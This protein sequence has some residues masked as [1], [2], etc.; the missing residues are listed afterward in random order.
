M[1]WNTRSAPVRSTR[2]A[3]PEYFASNA[4][5]TRSAAGRSSE[6][7]QTTLPSF[8]AASI[9]A[10]VTALAGGAA[11]RTEVAN[12]APATSA[13]EPFRTSRL[14]NSGLFIFVHSRQSSRSMAR[15]V[16]SALRH[17]LHLRPAIG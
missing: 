9:K 1:R 11:A 13:V 8:L 17:P 14:E 2:T 15:P 10:G 4:L 7:Y 12:A 5:A 6:V 3:M 16:A